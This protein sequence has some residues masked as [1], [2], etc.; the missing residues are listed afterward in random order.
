M[1]LSRIRPIKACVQAGIGLMLSVTVL[2]C[3]IG[4]YQYFYELTF[5]SNFLTGVFF[6]YAAICTA[7]GREAPRILY[8]CFTVLLFLVFVI[9]VGFPDFF[10]T[11]GLFAFIHIVNPLVVAAYFLAACDTQG[12]K[13]PCFLAPLAMPLAYILF[14]LIF[15]AAT[16]QHIYFFLDYQTRGIGYTVAFILAAGVFLLLASAL[17]VFLNRCLHKNKGK[18]ER[19]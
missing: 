4:Y 9:C 6:L 10:N 12:M 1:S 11:A 3:Y 19:E 5:L 17:F 15:G 8:L 2:V 7:A 14:A 16:G 13:L 18:P